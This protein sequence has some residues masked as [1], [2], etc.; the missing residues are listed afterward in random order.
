M[1]NALHELIAVVCFAHGGGGKGDNLFRA[2][3]PRHFRKAR[4][5][6]GRPRNSRLREKMLARALALAFAFALAGMKLPFAQP[7]HL[8]LGR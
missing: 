1:A 3:A 6:Q 5:H 2:V 4:A 8:L 7:D